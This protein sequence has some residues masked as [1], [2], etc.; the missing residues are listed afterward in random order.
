MQG[1]SEQCVNLLLGFKGVALVIQHPGLGRGLQKLYFLVIEC[2]KVGTLLNGNIECTEDINFDSA[3][4]YTCDP[5][6][7]LRGSSMRRCK[8]DS[9][10]TGDAPFCESMLEGFLLEAI[11]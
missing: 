3:C 2:E 6:Y 4:L 7:K 5:G 9:S 10:W 8:E 1:A 11:M